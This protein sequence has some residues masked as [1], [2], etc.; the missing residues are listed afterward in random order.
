MP[1]ARSSEGTVD[2]TAIV[3]R[4]RLVQPK[5]VG[6]NIHREEHGYKIAEQKRLI[7]RGNAERLLPLPE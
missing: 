2:P 5:C 6:I 4:E 1:R 7:L 3:A